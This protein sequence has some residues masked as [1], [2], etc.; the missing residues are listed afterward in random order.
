MT[1][2]REEREYA[3]NLNDKG[4]HRNSSSPISNRNSKSPYKSS[5]RFD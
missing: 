1:K 3:K 5:S 2:A 4:L